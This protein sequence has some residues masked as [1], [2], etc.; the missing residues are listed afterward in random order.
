MDKLRLGVVGAKYA[1]YL[2][3][4]RL[5]CRSVQLAAVLCGESDRDYSFD[6]CALYD[7]REQFMR[8]GIEA[9]IVA[10]D[11]TPYSKASCAARALRSGLDVMCLPMLVSTLDE[12]YSLE[13]A[14]RE[15]RRF[16]MYNEP[17]CFLPSVGFARELVRGGA[18]GRVLYA[19][20]RAFLPPIRYEQADLGRLRDTKHSTSRAA[21]LPSTYNCSGAVGPLVYVTGYKPIRVT[22]AEVPRAEYMKVAGAQNGSAGVELLEFM[23][24]AVG[25]CLHGYLWSDRGFELT[26]QGELGLLNVSDDRVVHHDFSTGRKVSST[27]RP[28]HESIFGCGIYAD[29]RLHASAYALACFVGLIRGNIRAKDAAIG[30]YS[31]LDMSL[32][33]LMAYRSVLDGGRAFA[34]PD[35]SRDE[36]RE[37][38]RRNRF[39]TDPDAPEKY[40]LPPRK[41]D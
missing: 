19:E 16:F 6:E 2:L 34:I 30:I 5:I 13:A 18:I 4:G 40:R 17:N 23:Y 9:V 38:C 11:D 28:A 10:D 24:G 15:S 22:G 25:R 14:V 27:Y 36:G 35:L 37:F 29:E 8:S 21:Y 26:L 39:T 33:G 20:S 12:A 3:E 1:K 31:A 7:D 32:P 41:K